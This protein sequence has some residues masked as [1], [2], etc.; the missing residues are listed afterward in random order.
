MPPGT[1]DADRRAAQVTPV[2][3]APKLSVTLAP[4]TEM[5]PKLVTVTVYVTVLVPLARMVSP[6]VLSILV[7]CRS[8]T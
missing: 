3:P 4:V 6:V 7:I 5:D 8:V 1:V 2:S